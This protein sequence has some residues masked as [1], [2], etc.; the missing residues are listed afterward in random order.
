[1]GNALKTDVIGGVV[2]P[3]V[4]GGRFFTTACP[5]IEGIAGI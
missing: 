3:L 4:T 2:G 1:M 5:G